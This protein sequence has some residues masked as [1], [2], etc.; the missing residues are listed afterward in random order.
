MQSSLVKNSAWG[1][2][3]NI[4][5]IL[6][7]CAFFAIVAR[8]YSSGEFAR[9]L[10]STSVYQIVAAFSSMG[11]GQW[12][13]RQYVLEDDKL[14]FTGK[15]L[16]T[17]IGLGLLFYVV[18]LIFAFV[19]YAD[20]Q[21]RFLC[22]ILGT[23]IIFDNLI[24][25]IRSLNIAENQQRKTAAILVIDGFLKLVSGCLL[26]VH[27][28]S[29][30]ILSV[31]MIVARV[32]TLGLFIKLGSSNSINI[33][34]LW[35]AKI[36]IE[37]LK[38]L[39]IK[40]WQFI[41]IGSISII[42]WKMGNIIISKT[43]ALSSV[44]DYEIAFRIFSVLLILPIVASSTIYPQFIKHFNEGNHAALTRLY[45][46]VF[47]IYTLFAIVSYLFMYS[48]SGW[49]L[50]LA[51]G[52]GYPGSVLC[53]Q[54]MFLTFLILPTVLLQANLIV[55]IGLEKLDMWFNIISLGVNVV[56]C[57][58][59]LYFIRE[60]AVINYSVFFSFLV[61]HILQDILL[62]RKKITTIKHCLLFYSGLL[63]IVLA[64][65]HFTIS[66]NPVVLFILFSGGI[67]LVAVSVVLFKKRK[68]SFNLLTLKKPTI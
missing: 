58:A 16:K 41:I 36:S 51:F 53:T 29:V 67:F 50:P 15:F 3:S 25:A 61:F 11:L 12:F 26:F 63:L 34:F 45:R 30:V 2:V 37:D 38:L 31:I 68:S 17:Q 24:N 39:I 32:L 27:P 28:F 1:I 5:Q 59:G 42:Y 65:H 35:R 20:V 60:L 6:F 43:L 56:G 21:I 23:N 40:N 54:Q 14:T 18:N 48:F 66:T 52:K 62:I 47:F 33:K 44:A 49:I 57:F 8:K 4:L 64:Y 55:A 9:F 10:V 7:I 13:I 19:V 46:T 22:I